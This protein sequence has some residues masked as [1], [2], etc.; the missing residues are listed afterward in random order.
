MIAICGL[1][2]VRLPLLFLPDVPP[3]LFPVAVCPT[4]GYT[5]NVE[6]GEK[7]RE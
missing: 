4:V 1:G 3:F 6:T 2:A 7:Q 5:M